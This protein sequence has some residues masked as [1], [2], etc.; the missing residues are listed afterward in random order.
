MARRSSNF[1]VRFTEFATGAV[2]GIEYH[3]F[4]DEDAWDVIEDRAAFHA[5]MRGVEIDI[6]TGTVFPS[7][8]IAGCDR[9]GIRVRP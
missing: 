2:C 4:A 8:K 1:P 9:A 5:R 6:E 7:G 3:G